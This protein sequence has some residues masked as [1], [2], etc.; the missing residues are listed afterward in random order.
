MKNF[1]VTFFFTN[2][3]L[4]ICVNTFLKRLKNNRKHGKL[5]RLR[6]CEHP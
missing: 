6:P 3:A 1:A 2:F 4:G 5:Q